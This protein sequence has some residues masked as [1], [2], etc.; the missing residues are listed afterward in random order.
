MKYLLLYFLTVQFLWSC[1]GDPV[2]K[3]E[4]T[5]QFTT[6]EVRFLPEAVEQITR[7]TDETAI[8]DINF[9][10][11]GRTNGV[12]LHLYSHA[13]LLRF[14]CPPGEYD[15]YVAANLH[16]DLGDK[17]IEELSSYTIAYNSSYANLPMSAQKVVT[18][19]T[20][21]GG[22]VTLPAI[23]LRRNIAKIG[24]NIRVA[25]GVSDIRLAS[26]QV[27]NIPGKAAPFCDAAKPSVTPGDYLNTTITNIPATNFRVYSGTQYLFENMQ[28]SVPSIA[29]QS[30]KS[31]KNAPK[32]ASYLL[33]RATRGTKALAYTVYFGQNNTDNFDVRRNSYHTLNITIR[34]DN[35][36]DTRISSYT[37]A[38]SD[39][40]GAAGIYGGYCVQ[41]PERSLY[42][43][44]QGQNNELQLYAEIKIS[45]GDA[46]ALIFEGEVVGT[47]R[48]VA[49]PNSNG[50]NTFGF[51]YAPL[52]FD[53]ATS[54]LAYTVTISDDYGMSQSFNFEYRF[55]S[56]IRVFAAVANYTNGKGTV[57]A[58][59]AVYAQPITG[60]S[61]GQL[62]LC[63][64]NGCTLTANPDIRF[65]FD[66][67]YSDPQ[68]TKLLTSSAAYVYHPAVFR[69]EVFAK[70]TQIADIPLDNRG[71][72]NCYITP[73]LKVWYS[74]DATT[75]GNGAWTKN[76]IPR[77]LSGTNALV[78]W[79]TG[80]VRGAVI[81]NAIWE[82]NRIYIE[83]GTT[84]GNAVIGLFN[85]SGECVWSWHIWAVNYN[86]E[87][88]AQLYASGS[89]FMDRNL[90]ALTIDYTQISSRGLYYQW[91]RKDPFIYPATFAANTGP[92]PG[93]YAEGFNYS[94]NYPADH[95]PDDEMTI[96]WSVQH[97]TTYMK[98]ALYSDWD[99][100]QDIMDWLYTRHPNLW[101]NRSTNPIIDP[102]TSKS[103][104][105]PCPPGWR[106]PE[107]NKF[108]GI[109]FKSWTVPYYTTIY[110]N[111]TQ[112]TNY[113]LGNCFN[114]TTFSQNGETG[115]IYT[116][117][118][119]FF[120][121][122]NLKINDYDCGS[123]SF[124]DGIYATAYFRYSADPIRCVKE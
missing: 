11:F 91:G 99:G 96:E 32:F 114:G 45:K 88:T 57:T 12:R 29:D 103:I 21:K 105:D 75:M 80:T 30:Q 3:H 19:S 1:A 76:I 20:V 94:I 37:L 14:E 117:S 58:S 113:P 104:Y 41:S 34:G 36:I 51:D 40:I 71:T 122:S 44:V 43:D 39:D 48:K 25:A 17:S 90:G 107:L 66:G 28:G 54:T 87:T 31:A 49:L 118:P 85:S 13:D 2:L 109:T 63:N 97:P 15:L 27:M 23:N 7:A 73:G 16:T 81:K 84:R 74:F 92:A 86:P 35:E 8:I 124:R 79:E 53:T 108:K 68:F 67:W 50:K 64:L 111:G 46:Q 18:I 106:V 60:T 65:R 72:S 9:Y 10:L 78:L 119:Y 123:L 33:I 121:S 22:A 5:P 56:V 77:K 4:V 116:S 89:A 59:E 52:R 102:T 24:Y 112:T 47:G 42:I 61:P 70:F 101:G 100:R 93:V 38:V 62:V 6:V 120:N 83:T 55:G 69:T 82:N 26:V 115:N 98:C 95:E 110:Y